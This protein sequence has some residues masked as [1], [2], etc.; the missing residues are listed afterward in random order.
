MHHKLCLQV[1]VNRSD[2]VEVSILLE[3]MSVYLIFK[4]KF[5][6]KDSSILTN[7]HELLVIAETEIPKF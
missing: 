2:F 4:I 7:I 1:C 6:V 3:N 5:V